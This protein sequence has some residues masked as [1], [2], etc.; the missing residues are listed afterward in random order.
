MSTDQR[1]H[2]DDELLELVSKNFPESGFPEL[3]YHHK[4]KDLLII[5]S[6]LRLDYMGYVHPDYQDTP[7][8]NSRLCVYGG[9]NKNFILKTDLEYQ[10]YDIVFHPREPIFA[11]ATGVGW[12]SF[13]GRLYLIN[14]ANQKIQEATSAERPVFRCE[15][16]DENL[17]IYTGKALGYIESIVEVFSKSFTANLSFDYRADPVVP[18]NLSAE[19]AQ[20]LSELEDFE[21][22]VGSVEQRSQHLKKILGINKK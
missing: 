13:K 9:K 22:K 5:T 2:Q 16:R 15:L 4:N 20:R 10:V 8:Y 1:T 19:E 18:N 12:D 21:Q 11:C 14:Y 6:S 7:H 3:I 17:E